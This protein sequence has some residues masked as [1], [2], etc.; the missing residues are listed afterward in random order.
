MQERAMLEGL[1]NGQENW[2]FLKVAILS[3]QY[4]AIDEYFLLELAF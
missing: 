2:H 3:Q 1:P 4:Y